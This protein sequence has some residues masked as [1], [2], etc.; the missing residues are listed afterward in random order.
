MS[1]PG[2]DRHPGKDFN[3]SP[4]R[5]PEN[6]PLQ[7]AAYPLEI[8]CVPVLSW[9]GKGGRDPAASPPPPMPSQTGARSSE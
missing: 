4:R 9:G 3:D 5:L 2:R 1:S 7:T 8:N 6:I